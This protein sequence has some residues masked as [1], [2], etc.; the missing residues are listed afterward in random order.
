M[1]EYERV[2]RMQTNTN[3]LQDQHTGKIIKLQADKHYKRGAIN[4]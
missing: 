4:R 1:K 3:I 2:K